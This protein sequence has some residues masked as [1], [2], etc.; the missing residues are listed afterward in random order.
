MY[1]LEKKKNKHQQNS[2]NLC[3]VYFTIVP[4][5][6]LDSSYKFFM[7]ILRPLSFPT[8][9]YSVRSST[10]YFPNFSL[11]QKLVAASISYGIN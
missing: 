11:L 1:T 9:I 3:S 7:G 8:P 6:S 2:K 5:K 4:A 10:L